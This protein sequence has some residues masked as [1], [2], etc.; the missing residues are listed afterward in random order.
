MGPLKVQGEHRVQAGRQLLGLGIGMIQRDA[1][2]NV[3]SSAGGGQGGPDRGGHRGGHGS[4]HGGVIGTFFVQ[5]L[6]A[7]QGF[8]NKKNINT[9]R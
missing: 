6:F 5:L 7:Q 1:V 3:L 9:E 4:V 2:A 8:F